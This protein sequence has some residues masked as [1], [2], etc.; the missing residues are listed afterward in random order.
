M[1]IRTF[2]RDLLLWPFQNSIILDHVIYP[3]GFFLQSNFHV[4]VSKTKICLHQVR[5]L[6]HISFLGKPQRVIGRVI[7]TF[8]ANVKP[9]LREPKKH[10][11]PISWTLVES[12]LSLHSVMFHNIA[13]LQYSF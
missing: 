9:A 13:F 10:C 4:F 11:S 12:S 8:A 6:Y 7:N 2:I 3:H 1:K 5:D